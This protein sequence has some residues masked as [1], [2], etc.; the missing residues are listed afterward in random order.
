VMSAIASP[1]DRFGSDVTDVVAPCWQISSD[2]STAAAVSGRTA[3]STSRNTGDGWFAFESARGLVAVVVNG[4]CSAVNN[5]VDHN[6]NR[7]A[8]FRLNAI[9]TLELMTVRPAPARL[10][11]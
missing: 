3:P 9:D 5:R 8:Q 2:V 10:S 1:N 6:G 4:V 11:Q 7:T